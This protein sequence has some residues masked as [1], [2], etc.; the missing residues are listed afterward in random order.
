MIEELYQEFN[1]ADIEP[2]Q[3]P[4]LDL[5]Y[6]GDCVYELTIRTNLL[7]EGPASVDKLNRRA[8][9]LAKA[10]TQARMAENLRDI[11]TEEEEAVFKRGRNAKVN[12][13]AKNA[14][15]SDYHKATGFEALIGWLYLNKDYAR[16]FE[17]I[18]KGW[19]SL[20]NAEAG[21]KL[22]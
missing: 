3:F 11:M 8:S 14:T 12:S 5:A 21:Q 13:P 22:E 6:I 15:I 4:S 1:I 10:A 7:N 2:S 16:L 17:L 19:E 18:R 9:S 20:E